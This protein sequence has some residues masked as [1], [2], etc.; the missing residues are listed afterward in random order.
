MPEV[1]DE[2]MN[3]NVKP[4]KKEGEAAVRQNGNIKHYSNPSKQTRGRRRPLRV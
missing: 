1:S 3:N 2:K 4:S